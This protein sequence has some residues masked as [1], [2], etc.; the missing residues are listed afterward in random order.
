M[1]HER[2]MIEYFLSVGD[3][4]INPTNTER[5]FD[6]LKH[7]KKSGNLFFVSN[8]FLFQGN[9]LKKKIDSFI[10]SPKRFEM[11]FTNT[12][13]TRDSARP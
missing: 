5:R 7:E 1:H 4:D 12:S 13:V 2:M 3:G 10:K 8:L 11:S 9:E 6:K